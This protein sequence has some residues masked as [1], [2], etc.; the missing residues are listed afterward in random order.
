MNQFKDHPAVVGWFISDEPTDGYHDEALLAYNTIKAL[1]SHPVSIVFCYTDN[2]PNAF[3]DSYNT[4]LFDRYPCRTGDSEFDYARFQEFKSFLDWGGSKA[5]ELGKPWMAVLQAFGG[6]SDTLEFRLPT[7]DEARF[8]TYYAIEAG[9]S[10]ALFYPRYRTTRIS[11]RPGEAYPDSG[12]QWIDDVFEPLASEMNA[13]SAAIGAGVVDGLVSDD[14]LDVRTDLYQDPDTDEYYL[15]ALNSTLGSENPTFT[16]DIAGFTA[17]FAQLLFESEL[18][19]PIVDGEFSYAFADYDVHAF[20]LILEELSSLPGDANLDDK[21]DVTDLGLLA[22]GWQTA[23]GWG[24]GDFD[25]SGFVDVTDLGI[26]ATHW[27][28]GVVSQ[29]V[30]PTPEPATMSLLALG[31]LA[32]IRRK[33]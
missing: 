16:V 31:G 4:L 6:W 5:T 30:T 17:T 26:L 33:K 25:G 23:Q 9:A 24:L 32:L 8:M 12:T 28:E 20:K 27:Q 14:S 1:S 29:E 3:A 22:T 18:M 21:V 13:L 15:V 7:S 2:K 10:G 11:A 19:I